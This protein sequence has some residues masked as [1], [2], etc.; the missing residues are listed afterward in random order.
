MKIDYPA[1]E[2]IPQLRTLWTAAFDDGDEFL[3]QFFTTA[4]SPDRCRCALVEDDV[5]AALYWFDVTCGDAPMAY[6]YAVATAPAYREQGFCNALMAD[7]HALLKELGYHG[8]ILVPDGDA[9]TKMYAG[10]G[11]SPCSGIKEFV[12]AP[13]GDPATM[14]KVDTA[15]YARIRR[16][17][18]PPGSVVQEGVSLD[19]LATLADLYAGPGFLLA[20][21]QE[22]EL[23]QGLELLGDP[24]LAP[25]ILLHLG[26][27]YGSF[28]TP[29]TA[30]PFA[31]FLPLREDAP[32]PAY[33]GLAFD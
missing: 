11:Y 3:D 16:R 32:V 19:F 24:S 14:H 9:L 13:T 12:C 27:S 26:L 8:A 25:G 15:E 7:T 2:H 22:G 6:I 33:F 4:F 5:A 17:L 30:A 20:A 28:R 18:L 1:T 29:G 23:L 10:F 31:M 21:R